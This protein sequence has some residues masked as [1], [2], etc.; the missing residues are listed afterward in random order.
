[1]AESREFV[2][3]ASETGA[4]HTLYMLRAAAHATRSLQ[5]LDQVIACVARRQLTPAALEQSLRAFLST[6][7]G[8]LERDARAATTRFVGG[9]MSSAI[10]PSHDAEPRVDI[11]RSD[12]D[13]SLERVAREATARAAAAMSMYQSSIDSLGAGEITLDELRRSLR[14]EYN[15]SVSR[16]LSR[17]AE[18]WFGLLADLD[19]MRAKLT[20]QYLLDALRSANPIGFDG[21]GVELTGRVNTTVSTTVT[22]ENTMAEQVVLRCAVSDVRRADAIGP[23]FVPNIVL[24]PAELV[25]DADRIATVA[26]SLWLDDAIYDTDARY[27][28]ALGISRDGAPRVDVPLSITPMTQALA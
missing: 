23:A 7:A 20:E 13:G 1:M 28:G 16:E 11:D 17:A 5:L 26:V 27:I 4:A 19:D 8:S 25:V 18:L 24:T 21:D 12:L 10:V 9:L 14:K 15:R 2:T 6:H 22:L 3:A